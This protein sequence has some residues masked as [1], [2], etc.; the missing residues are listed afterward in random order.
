MQCWLRVIVVPAKKPFHIHGLASYL[1]HW[2]V[3]EPTMPVLTC[4]LPPVELE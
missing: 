3:G 2:R 4:I 1:R